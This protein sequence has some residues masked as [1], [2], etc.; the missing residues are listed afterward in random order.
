M[1]W[2]ICR[3]LFYTDY[4]NQLLKRCIVQYHFT[5]EEQVQLHGNSKQSEPYIHTMPS[6]LNKL[7]EVASE[8]M[9]K[10]AVHAVSSQHGGVVRA[11]SAGSLATK[12]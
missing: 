1:M 6:T 9:P 5:D 4:D 11:L 10:P 3:S 2:F 7:T 8:T 12:E